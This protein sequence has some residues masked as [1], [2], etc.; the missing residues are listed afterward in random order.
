MRSW[1][2]KVNGLP[3]SDNT[4]HF[5]IITNTLPYSTTELLTRLLKL[6]RTVK[7]TSA[8]EA[9]EYERKIIK[10]KKTMRKEL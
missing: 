1:N 9:S 3:F 2:L 5:H 7:Y 6:V 10:L 8:S 4:L